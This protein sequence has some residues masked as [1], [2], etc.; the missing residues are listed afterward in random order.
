MFKECKGSLDFRREDFRLLRDMLGRVQ[1]SWLIPEDHL[2]KTQN[3]P[4]QEVGNKAKA[5]GGQHR[6]GVLTEHGH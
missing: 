1:E 5:A 6:Q 3:S 2:S 4:F